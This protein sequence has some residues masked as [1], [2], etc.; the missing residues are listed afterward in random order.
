MFLPQ[1]Y[2]QITKPNP[3]HIFCKIRSSKLTAKSNIC[4]REEQK[5]DDIELFIYSHLSNIFYYAFINTYLFTY[6]IT[7]LLTF[8]LF[9]FF[10]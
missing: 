5:D 3:S 4:Y 6:L 2:I 10:I 9:Y 1:R 7:Y 8:L